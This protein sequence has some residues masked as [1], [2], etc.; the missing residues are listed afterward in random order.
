[1]TLPKYLNRY[2]SMIDDLVANGFPHSVIISGDRGCG[3]HMLC[4]YIM[5]VVGLTLYDGKITKDVIDSLYSVNT[6][7][8]VVID[9]ADLSDAIIQA[10]LK[11]TE[12]PPECV[13][14]AFLTR[15][16][17]FIIPTIKNRCMTILVRQMSIP[18]L[19]EYI[20]DKEHAEEIAK[21]GKTVGVV[22]ELTYDKI[23]EV[24]SLCD[25]II[26]KIKVASYPNTL[27]LVNRFGD[28]GI[29]LDIFF[30]IMKQKISDYVVSASLSPSVALEAIKSTN[31]FEYLTSR[32]AN[33]KSTIISG[34]FIRLKEILR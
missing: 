8:L 25:L 2:G 20:D 13:Y 9:Y 11:I 34:Y 17:D 10:L 26:S 27:T 3:K 21:V 22:S 30:R 32:Y 1:M 24:A 23:K 28:D 12:E 7:T 18:E 4:D 16:V 6:K 31:D 14:F 19:C 33:Q 5:Q 15:N 29:G